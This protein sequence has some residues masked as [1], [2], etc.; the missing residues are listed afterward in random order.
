[1]SSTQP[2]PIVTYED[3]VTL[4]SGASDHMHSRRQ[5][6]Y[7]VVAFITDVI[8]PDGADIKVI[9]AGILRVS[10]LDLLTRLRQ[11]IPLL[12]TLHVL[13]LRTTLWSVI[14]IAQCG[15]TII[16]GNTT[17]R[18]ILH[19][20]RP[21]SFELRLSRPLYQRRDHPFGYC[22]TTPAFANCVIT[23]N[24][25]IGP[26]AP[27]EAEEGK[28]IVVR[29]QPARTPKLVTVE[30]LHKRLGHVS[31]KAILAAN[32]AGVWEDVTVR[33]APRHFASTTRLGLLALPIAVNSLLDMIPVPARFSFVLPKPTLPE[34]V[35]PNNLITR[36]T[37][38]RWFCFPN[39]WLSSVANSLP[40]PQLSPA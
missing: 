26:A 35:S 24:S 29:A 10:C 33:F 13:G 23:A 18:I 39:E 19:D 25:V 31:T 7:D 4:D 14:Q 16:F 3:H 11:T 1:M 17:I 21:E 9:E 28:T 38:K 6:L 15:H 22:V 37:S 36:T 12:N 8:L 20:G 2:L 27:T 40:P 32:E 30:R 5:D 34:L